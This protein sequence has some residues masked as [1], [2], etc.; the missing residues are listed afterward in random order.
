ML[1]LHVLVAKY[2]YTLCNA[3]FPHAI[4]V[5]RHQAISRTSRVHIRWY[6]QVL[7]TSFPVVMHP[8]RILGSTRQTTTYIQTGSLR[9]HIG[10]HYGTTFALILAVIEPKRK[11]SRIRAS[12]TS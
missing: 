9:I 8:I 1:A 7:K 12:D 10:H 11:K 4:H 6:H 3:T 5:S 2:M